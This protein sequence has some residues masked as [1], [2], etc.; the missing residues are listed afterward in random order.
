[1]SDSQAYEEV[2]VS[3]DGISVVKRFEEDEFPVPAIAFE[4]ASER[5][6]DVLVRLTDAV[7]E[8]VEVE[9]LGFH[10]EY[11][12][13]HW[14]IDED[15]ITFERAISAGAEYTT[16]YGIRATG[17]DDVEQFLSEPTIEEVDPPSAGSDAGQGAD[18]IIS[19]SDDDVVRDVISGEGEVPGLEDEDDETPQDEDIDTLDL[20]DPNAT[21]G[22]SAPTG[23]SSDGDASDEDGSDEDGSDGDASDVAVEGSVVAAMANEI[24]ENEVSVED[25]ELLVKAV[26]E[27]SD[28]DEEP[29]GVNEARIERIQGDIADLRAYTDALE[30]FLDENGTG[31]QLISGFEEQ[32]EEFSSDLEAMQ[33][34]VDSTAET[35]E[36]VE[37]EMDDLQAEMESVSQTVEDLETTVEDLEEQVTEGDLMERIEDIEENLGDLQDWQDQIRSTFGG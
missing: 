21:D 36:S 11:G 10:P 4:F 33:S 8:G 5:D 17:T 30:E 20:K 37:G 28:D 14:T 24:R 3:S 29:D 25:M 6:D 9:D 16:V 13:E 18:G 15:H 19:E 12:S 27:L 7:P 34:E 35:V 22:A 31:E 32:L 1:M 23:D 26:E 2:A